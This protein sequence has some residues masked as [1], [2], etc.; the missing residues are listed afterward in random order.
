MAN[1]AVV[2]R[3]CGL[4]IRDEDAVAKVGGELL[5]AACAEVAYAGRPEWTHSEIGTLNQLSRGA[6]GGGATI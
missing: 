4:V 3:L 6:I 1:E 2:C 5:H